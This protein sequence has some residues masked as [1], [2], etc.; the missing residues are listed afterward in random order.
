MPS[1][2]LLLFLSPWLHARVNLQRIAFGSCNNQGSPQALWK[3][4]LQQKPDLW[5]W[6]GDN[7]YADWT[8]S[9]RQEAYEL[10][11]Q[12]PLYQRLRSQTQIMGTW[13]EHENAL[14]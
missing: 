14:G 12:H 2:L 7:I 8:R 3:D 6:G 4:V 5:I 11:K 9:P 1:F 10:Q 13:D